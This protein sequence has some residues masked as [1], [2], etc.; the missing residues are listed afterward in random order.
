MYSGGL[1]APDALAAVAL[2]WAA[3]GALHLLLG[4]PGAA[5]TGAQVAG[6]LRRI[7]VDPVEVGRA[8]GTI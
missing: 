7:G 3:G 4:A 8:D 1:L 5:P 6:A 2:G